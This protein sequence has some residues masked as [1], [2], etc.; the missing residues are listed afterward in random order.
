MSNIRSGKL[1]DK[2]F[3]TVIVCAPVA[4]GVIESTIYVPLLFPSISLN[5]FPA[6]T[7]LI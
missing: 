4:L 2:S 1:K 7:F 3:E 6:S 5:K